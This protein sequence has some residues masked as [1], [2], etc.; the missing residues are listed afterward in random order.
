MASISKDQ[1]VVIDRG[2][3]LL[4]MGYDPFFLSDLMIH[5]LI[6]SVSLATNHQQSKLD[7]TIPDKLYLCR[8]ID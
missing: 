7:S 3:L 6:S 8:I 5:V 4:E 2:E 1:D